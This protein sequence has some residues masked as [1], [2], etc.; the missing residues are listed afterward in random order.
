MW[1]IIFKKNKKKRVM[2]DVKF[3]GHSVKATEIN[4]YKSI[5]SLMELKL[6]LVLPDDEIKFIE[7]EED[8]HFLEPTKMV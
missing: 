8:D 7:S 6:T 3:N 5:D 4:F 2:I 1:E